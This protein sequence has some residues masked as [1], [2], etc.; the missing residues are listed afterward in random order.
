MNTLVRA[1]A[2]ASCLLVAGSALAYGEWPASGRIVFEVLRGEDGVKLGE[3]EHRWSQDGRTYQ[4]STVVETTGLAGLLYDFRYVQRSS[5]AI[6]SDRLMPSRF[7]VV[8]QDRPEDVAS[9]DWS[10]GKVEIARRERLR[11][12]PLGPGDQDVLSVWHLFAALNGRE[13]PEALQLVTNRGAYPADIEIVGNERLRLALGE[14][15]VRH[16]KLVARSGRLAIDVWLSDA[17]GSLPVRVLMRDD[18]GQVLDQRAIR[19]ETGNRPVA[20]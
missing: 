11:S 18:R 17:H 15:A 3:S 20:E 14:L 12:Y 13:P 6:E 7:S 16:V 19:I 4:M 8:Q 2:L 1:L 9:F 5:G 10:V